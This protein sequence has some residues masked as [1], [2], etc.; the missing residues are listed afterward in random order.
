MQW[1]LAQGYTAAEVYATDT[2]YYAARGR[3]GA[4]VGVQR[5]LH[6]S[7][8]GVHRLL[9]EGLGREGHIRAANRLHHPFDADVQTELDIAWAA[10]QTAQLAPGG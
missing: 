9:P 5:G 3:L 7:A 6:L 1:G 2:Q 4:G 10:Y 8:A